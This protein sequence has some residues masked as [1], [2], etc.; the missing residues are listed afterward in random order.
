MTELQIKIA[1][2]SLKY[3]QGGTNRVRESDL[4]EHLDEVFGYNASIDSFYVIDT[5]KKDYHLLDSLGQAWIR[6]TS[7]GELAVTSGFE[8]YLD[9]LK[10]DKELDKSVKTSTIRSNYFNITNVCITLI[11]SIISALITIGILTLTQ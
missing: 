8:K 9:E 10:L 5:L 4:L 3:L 11:A 6:I 7:E 2:E 1:N